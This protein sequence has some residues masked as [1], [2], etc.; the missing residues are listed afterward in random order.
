MGVSSLDFT[1]ISHQS[2]DMAVKTGMRMRGLRDGSE[3]RTSHCHQS[4]F[5]EKCLRLFVVVVVMEIMYYASFT[6][7]RA[8][9]ASLRCEEVE[10]C[11]RFL[12]S[13]WKHNHHGNDIRGIHT[14]FHLYAC[15]HWKVLRSEEVYEKCL[16]LFAVV[17]TKM[18]CSV[19]VCG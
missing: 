17:Y 8:K 10:K 18:F 19:T 9:L 12:W 11:L 7:I 5:K 4:N 13:S 6:S 14:K 15:Y 3:E 1:E 16:R 2:P